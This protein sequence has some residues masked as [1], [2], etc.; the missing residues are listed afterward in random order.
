MHINGGARPESLSYY[1]VHSQINQVGIYEL[2]ML[3]GAYRHFWQDEE[4]SYC[5]LILARP[6]ASDKAWDMLWQEVTK[7]TRRQWKPPQ[8]VSTQ[9]RPSIYGCPRR[10]RRT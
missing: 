5:R 2:A 7:T 1:P 4:D 6:G 9:A 8:A 3:R 10:T